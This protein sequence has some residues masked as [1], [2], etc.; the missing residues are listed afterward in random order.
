MVSS[1]RSTNAVVGATHGEVPTGFFERLISSPIHLIRISRFPSVYHWSEL[2]HESIAAHGSLF[3]VST[4]RPVTRPPL[5]RAEQNVLRDL[6]HR[7]APDGQGDPRQLTHYLR[8]FQDSVLQDHRICAFHVNAH[9]SDGSVVLT[10]YAEFV[11]MRNALIEFL[12]CL[13]FESITN[14]VELFPSRGLGELRFGLVRSAH[15]LVLTK[16]SGDSTTAT[17]VMLGE[18]LFLLH[19]VAP[20]FV[21]CHTGEGYVGFVRQSDILRIDADHFDRWLKGRQVYVTEQWISD[22]DA[23]I[24]VRAHL[25]WVAQDLE[26]VTAESPDGKTWQVPKSICDV[27][28]HVATPRTGSGPCDGAVNSSGPSMSGA[29][30]RVPASIARGSFKPRL[31]RAVFICRAIRTSRCFRGGW[32]PHAGTAVT[33]SAATRSIFSAGLEKS[34]TRGSTWATVNTSKP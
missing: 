8:S 4:R 23:T 14:N 17:D 25:R 13:G 2:G 10:G 32:L 19:D 33:C 5:G 22:R 28:G 21:L 34:R 24:P 29:A 16:P 11:E 27:R 9:V 6:A 20:E 18:P 15:S 3:V 1:V 7:L 12:R 31:R 30:R 26:H